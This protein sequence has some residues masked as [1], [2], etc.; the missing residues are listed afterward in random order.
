MVFLLNLSEDPGLDCHIQRKLF[1]E[2]KAEVSVQVHLPGFQECLD[3]KTD[4]MLSN[5]LAMTDS[6][7]RQVSAA[8]SWLE[9]NIQNVS[10]STIAMVGPGRFVNDNL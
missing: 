4:A 9:S 2:D 8:S 1:G 3:G 7:N 10:T 5:A 6:T